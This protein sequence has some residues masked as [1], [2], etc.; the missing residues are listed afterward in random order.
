[1]E[2]PGVVLLAFTALA[3]PTVI[4]AALVA[5]ARG[6]ERAAK[7]IGLTAAAYVALTAR[8]R[9]GAP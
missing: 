8:S 7:A 9:R 6:H 3:L 4:V 2:I 5:R 1:M